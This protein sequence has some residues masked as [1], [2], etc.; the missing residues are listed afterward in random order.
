MQ[1]FIIYAPTI[2]MDNIVSKSGKKQHKNKISTFNR[3]IWAQK[4]TLTFII[5]L[6]YNLYFK[7]SRWKLFI[8]T[9]KFSLFSPLIRV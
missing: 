2:L 1:V 9:Y 8:V 7:L 4:I 5:S 3:K 6:S